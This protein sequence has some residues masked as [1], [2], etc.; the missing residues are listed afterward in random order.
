MQIAETASHRLFQDHELSISRHVPEREHAEPIDRPAGGKVEMDQGRGNLDPIMPI[1]G[2]TGETGRTPIPVAESTRQPEKEI[3][4]PGDVSREEGP[5]YKGMP[6]DSR[7]MRGESAERDSGLQGR[8]ESGWVLPEP[9]EPCRPPGEG[10]TGKEMPPCPTDKSEREFPGQEYPM[11]LA[12]LGLSISIDI[13]DCWI[14]RNNP[15][16]TS[17]SIYPLRQKKN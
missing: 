4:T 10:T 7:Q 15:I 17:S 11:T 2:A 9:S 6:G 14:M 3:F 5:E 13:I 16:A 12:L 1:V 8:G